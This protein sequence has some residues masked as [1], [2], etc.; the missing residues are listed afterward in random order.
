MEW[1]APSRFSIRRAAASLHGSQ[2]FRPA[3]SAS[4]SD[5]G[6]EFVSDAGPLL[7]GSSRKNGRLGDPALPYLSSAFL[8]FYRSY[9]TR[10]F[11][12]LIII[13]LML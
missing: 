12:K 11:R 7:T 2:I 13:P 8:K 9:G 6:G 3:R 5:A 10:Q 1:E 4:R